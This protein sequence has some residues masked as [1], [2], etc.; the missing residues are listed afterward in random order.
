MKLIILNITPNDSLKVLN[1]LR[2]A[3]IYFT[4]IASIGGMISTGNYTYLIKVN[5]ELV[6]E[7]IKNLTTLTK[8]RKIKISSIN[9]TEMGMFKNIST[10]QK[11]GGATIFV[12]DLEQFIKV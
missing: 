12:V 1:Y 10:T 2:K 3:P 6:D 11:E 8:T 4:K 9:N 7:I 5:D